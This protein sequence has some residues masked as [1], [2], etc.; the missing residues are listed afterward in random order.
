MS[1]LSNLV[2]SY[3]DDIARAAGNKIDDVA[4]IA[5]NKADDAARIIANKSDDV[6]RI[7]ANKADDA[8]TALGKLLSPEQESY[9]KNSLARDADGNLIPLHHGSANGKFTVFDRSYGNPEGD[10]GK[11]FYF[12]DNADDVQ[13]NYFGGGPD[14]DN[15]VDRLAEQLESEL[16]IPM[17][18]AQKRAKDQLFKGAYQID[19]YANMENPATVGK[20]YLF[21]GSDYPVK[22]FA[23][24]DNI[25]DYYSDLLYDLADN[26]ASDVDMDYDELSKAINEVVGEAMWNGG[27]GVQ[28]L[29][30]ALNERYLEDFEGNVVGNEVARSILE[31]LGY[32]GI[33]DPTVSTKF[34][35]MGLAPDT[36]HYI[37]FQ[38]NQIKSISNKKPT[39]N[40]DIMLGL[41]GLV[42]GG[43][44]LGALL[45]SGDNAQNHA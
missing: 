7:A 25:E 45:G 14:F 41:G 5:A 29:K 28:E 35:N 27:I 37:A 30:D 40:P 6:A 21:D 42:G 43:T 36:T 22:D 8:S 2:S 33:I 13:R 31:S 4:R 23:D 17:E 24:Y 44:L 18:E 32:D 19:A 12:T 1:V 34:K 15:K 26:V 16:D 3:G 39:S 9:F 10:W 20:T 11:G 38:P